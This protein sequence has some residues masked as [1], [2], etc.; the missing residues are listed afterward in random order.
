MEPSKT[1]MMQIPRDEYILGELMLGDAICLLASIT[2]KVSDE[3]VET[4]LIRWLDYL[5]NRA[6]EKY[7][8]LSSEEVEEMIYSVRMTWREGKYKLD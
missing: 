4:V 7:Q 5:R 8:E 6:E 2:M 3:D 1:E